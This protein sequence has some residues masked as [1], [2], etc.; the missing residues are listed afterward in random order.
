M[1]D[2]TDPILDL[3]EVAVERGVGERAAGEQIQL[4]GAVHPAL[5]ALRLGPLGP[6]VHVIE[7]GVGRSRVHRAAGVQ[8]GELREPHRDDG[9]RE[10]GVAQRPEIGERLLEHRA[11][12]ERGHDHHLGVHLDAA[13]GEPR[14][15]LQDVRHA[16]IVEEHLTRF[17]RRR[18]HRDVEGRQ[19]ILED[20][21]DVAVLEVRERREIP[22]GEGEAVVVIAYVER[23]PQARRQPFDEAELAAV[24]AAPDRRRLE[25]HPERFP[26]GSLDVEGDRL[27]IGESALDRQL[28]VRRQE[29]PIEEVGELAPVHRVELG[30]G[31]DPHGTGDRIGKDAADAD[32]G[33]Y[34]CARGKIAWRDLPPAR[35]SLARHRGSCGGDIKYS[36]RSSVGKQDRRATS[37]LALRIHIGCEAARRESGEPL[38]IQLSRGRSGDRRVAIAHDLGVLHA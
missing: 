14:E 30:A 22:V 17:P 7:E 32:H 13:R 16:R 19:A 21:R 2:R 10:H 6:A 20:P 24:G 35:C 8:V 36:R 4:V 38:R 29:L 25:L 27:A 28:V 3:R 33:G 9:H 1:R 34:S 15:L 18:V 37:P 31:H 5:A 26:V 11:V 23:S 12:V